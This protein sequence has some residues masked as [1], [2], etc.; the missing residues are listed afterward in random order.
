M[1]KKNAHYLTAGCLL[2]LTAQAYGVDDGASQTIRQSFAAPPRACAST[3]AAAEL[4]S[5]GLLHELYAQEAFLP[6]W[7]EPSRR[8]ALLHELEQLADDGL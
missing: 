7:Q 2:A 4:Q 6:L 3:L 8:V 5:S 1:Y